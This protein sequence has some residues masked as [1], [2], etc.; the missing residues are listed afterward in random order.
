MSQTYINVEEPPYNATGD[1]VTDDYAA[2]IAALND[3]A[4]RTVYF[5]AGTYLVGA[6]LVPSGPVVL[7]GD[8]R[9]TATI[10]AS[11]TMSGNAVIVLPVNS[12][13][14]NITLDADF[15]SRSQ[16]MP[17][18]SGIILNGSGVKI[19]RCRIRNCSGAG[20]YG[21]G[22]SG[23]RITDSEI[24]N[25]AEQNINISKASRIL[26]SNCRLRRCGM[27]N[28]QLTYCANSQ[29]NRNI[30]GPSGPV[31]AGIYPQDCDN[32]I[33]EGNIITR[34]RG[35]IEAWTNVGRLLWTG[36][37][38]IINN[39]IS[40]NYNGGLSTGS[41]GVSIAGNNI[42]DN[43]HGGINS[44]TSTIEPGIKVDPSYGGTGYQQ[45]DILTLVGGTGTPA[46]V[47]VL[48]VFSGGSLH[49]GLGQGVSL[50]PIDMG[51]YS[52]FPTNPVAVTGG[53]G[54][55]AKV[56]YTNSTINSG[57]SGY[58]V[59]DLL[60]ATNGTFTQPVRLEVTAASG[61][62]VTAYELHDGGGYSDA[63]PMSLSF[64]TEFGGSGSGF[65]LIPCWGK[66]Y[67]SS[68]SW[69]YGLETVGPVLACSISS[70]IIT[71]T[72]EGPA[73]LVY[74]QSAPLDGRMNYSAIVA[75]VFRN[76]TY[77]IK[78]KTGGRPFDDTVPANNKIDR[79]IGYP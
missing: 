65:S 78:G 47:M 16:P 27:S 14:T 43:G 8:D 68:Y 35:G 6:R 11:S 17:I 66:R 51:N 29:I 9:D 44:V 20:I 73:V 19:D 15:A 7:L 59:G 2:V 55:G 18:I 40:R 34:C 76:N 3:A 77:S 22:T 46:K 70:N 26:I 32:L 57:G 53:H 33:I 42:S 25:T 50:Y 23:A 12:A 1:G 52:V 5:P 56:I 41:N 54:T 24:D 49:N 4:G 10:K 67:S 13:I 72:R 37:N 31:G 63:L 64:A 58:V 39:L 79:N 69:T 60:R 38:Q 30:I 45:Y 61:G 48:L 28:I 75:N 71:S 21:S 36:G 74:D 62:A